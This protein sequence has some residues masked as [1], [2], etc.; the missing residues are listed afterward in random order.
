MV[1]WVRILEDLIRIPFTNVRFG[2]DVILGVVP[3][4]GD[5][6]GL[7]CGLPLLVAAVRRRLP[8]AV[9]AVMSLNVLLDAVIGSIPL[10][11]DV[12]DLAWKSH[13][14]NLRLLQSPSSLPEVLQEARWKL[15]AI[16][17]IVVLLA[18]LL[19]ALLFSSLRLWTLLL[20]W[21]WTLW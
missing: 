14:K 2:L 9:V 19:V 6:A 13:R 3:V 11:G 12:F 4:I 5:F 16:L 18:V 21:G 1:Q 8:L 15:G 10:L 17:G 7:L 20:Q